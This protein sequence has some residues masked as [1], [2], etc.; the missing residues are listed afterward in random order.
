[1]LVIEGGTIEWSA[2]TASATKQRLDELAT[3]MSR[4]I[5]QIES[6]H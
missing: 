2:A 5:A 6:N 1:M 3:K 4:I